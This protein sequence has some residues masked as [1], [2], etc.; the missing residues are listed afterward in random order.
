MLWMVWCESWRTWIQLKR[1]RACKSCVDQP[2][3]RKV[4][5]NREKKKP[6]QNKRH[7][8][9]RDVFGSIPTG[10]LRANVFKIIIISCRYINGHTTFFFHAS[11]NRRSSTFY[12]TFQHNFN[13]LRADGKYNI[14]AKFRKQKCCEF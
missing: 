5:A 14:Q 8:S 1:R 3:A 12:N 10:V 2:R 11:Y 13:A 7:V 9:G 6:Q 4:Y